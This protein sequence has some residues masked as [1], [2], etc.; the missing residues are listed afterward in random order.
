MISADL[1]VFASLRQRSM[2]RWERDIRA[3]LLLHKRKLPLEL[4]LCTNKKSQTLRFRYYDQ[5]SLSKCVYLQN[6]SMM[7]SILSHHILNDSR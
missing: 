2:L 7:R 1:L 6:E 3:E 4:Q 5:S